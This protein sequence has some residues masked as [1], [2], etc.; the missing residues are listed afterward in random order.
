MQG[1]QISQLRGR[2]AAGTS[3]EILLGWALVLTFREGSLS[4]SESQQDFGLVLGML[5]SLVGGA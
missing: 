4:T 3:S 2:Q 1:S 5:P